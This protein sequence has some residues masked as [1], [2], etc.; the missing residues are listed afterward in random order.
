[1]KTFI[2]TTIE[3]ELRSYDLT[4]KAKNKKEAERKIRNWEEE[5]SSV[6]EF[7][8]TEGIVEIVSIE[9]V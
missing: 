4:V 2:V 7:V 3:K 9:E 8:D 6:S 1:M 5:D